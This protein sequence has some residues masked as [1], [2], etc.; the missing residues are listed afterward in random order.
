MNNRLS[1]GYD[2]P[3]VE[4]YQMPHSNEAEQAVLGAILVE[5]EVLHQ[6]LEMLRP[7][8][9]Y[10]EQ[11]REIFSAMSRLFHAG[12]PVDIVTVLNEL[13]QID[14]FTEQEGRQYLFSIA[15]N[16]P[17][18][19]NASAYAEIIRDKY[20]M[21]KLIEAARA[22]MDDAS[23]ESNNPREVLDHAEQRIY[24]ISGHRASQGLL[25]ISDILME[26][27]ERLGKISSGDGDEYVGIPTGLKLLDETIMGLN[28][29]DLILL[30]ARPGVGKTSFALNIA[31]NVA[32]KERRK[33]A[34]F[35]LEMTREQLVL[36]LISAESG[37]SSA[38]LREGHLSPE[39]W[40]DVIAC[41]NTLYNAPIYLDE[42]GDITVTEMKAKLRRLGD[43][44]LVIIDYLQLM[45]GGKI[46]NRVQVVG[47]ITRGLK[48]MAK[49]LNVPI[50]LLSQLNRST[51]SRQGHRPMLAD[52]RDSGSIEQDADIVLF[53][54]REA[55]YGDDGR[56]SG[57]VDKTKA[58]CIVAKNRHGE[59]RD[60]QLHWSGETTQFVTV[61]AQ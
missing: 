20:E 32:I 8:F 39:E 47:E 40:A 9:F 19:R 54:M 44:G 28:R 53:L 45:G 34:F 29:T 21:R 16:T 57:E 18:A 59:T 13:A 61:E 56:E 27:I 2:F 31:R 17:S 51:E 14:V 1:A 58:L 26:A 37:V 6:M 25:P 11:H 38:K 41:G 24:E 23:D 3:G 50:L 15:E 48:I 46:D 49:E 60:I 12:Q 33:V 10:N 35:S 5:R 30:A 36:R 7:D 55:M 22:I 43:V 52:L 4:R 42:A